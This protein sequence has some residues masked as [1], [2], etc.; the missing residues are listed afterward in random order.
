MATSKKPRKVVRLPGKKTGAR[1]K[2]DIAAVPLNAKGREFDYS[3]NAALLGA[4]YNILSEQQCVDLHV[5]AM[6]CIEC[7]AMGYIKTHAESVK[8]ITVS[9]HERGLHVS[10]DDAVSLKAS[11]SILNEWVHKQNNLRIAKVAKKAIG[12][13]TKQEA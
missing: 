12:I 4:D 6:M 5:L 11:C 9:I 13:L 10:V 2:N 1:I 8:R 3:N 7:G